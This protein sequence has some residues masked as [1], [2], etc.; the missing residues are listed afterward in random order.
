[1]TTSLSCR[2]S[3]ISAFCW[4]ATQP[5]SITNCLVA[6]VHT[7]PVTAVLAPTLVAMATTL[8]RSRLCLRRIAWP[9]KPTPRIKQRVASYSL[10][11]STF[12]PSLLKVG[13]RRTTHKFSPALPVSCCCHIIC[14]RLPSPVLYIIS[15]SS[16]WPS[17]AVRHLDDLHKYVCRGSV[18]WSCAQSIVISVSLQW[19]PV[20]SID[21][22]FEFHEFFF[23]LKIYRILRIFF[24]WKKFAKKS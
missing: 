7:K 12:P 14:R 5:P 20:L 22:E 16:P 6:I 13:D 2:V 23:I 9:Q 3:A 18:L 19:L 11:S 1:V 24:G 10:S 4:P 8:S 21:R 15:P 17:S